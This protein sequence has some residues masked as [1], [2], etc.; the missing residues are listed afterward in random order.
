V[1]LLDVPFRSCWR[2]SFPSA[3]LPVRSRKR[4]SRASIANA[5]YRWV[6]VAIVVASEACG[7]GS[8]AVD[9]KSAV[10]GSGRI[11]P[12]AFRQGGP[13]HKSLKRGRIRPPEF[14]YCAPAFDRVL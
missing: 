6:A 7:R 14:V 10:S 3:P 5:C 13:P 9:V 11:P 4:V 12:H 2:W 8:T 1:N